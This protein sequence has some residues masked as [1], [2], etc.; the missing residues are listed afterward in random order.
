MYT[1]R[2]YGGQQE[3]RRYVEQGDVRSC[4][5]DKVSAVWVLTV[6]VSATAV[7]IPERLT[8]LCGNQRGCSKRKSSNRLLH[9]GQ[10]TAVSVGTP[11]STVAAR[12]VVV[13][14]QKTLAR[15]DRLC[16][17]GATAVRTLALVEGV[18]SLHLLQAARWQLFA[19]C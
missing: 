17:R 13:T 5:C 9:H 16:G 19:F 12:D 2:A 1:C 18:S 3:N 14:S 15:G 7:N 4:C 11:A 10:H 8:L 6:Y